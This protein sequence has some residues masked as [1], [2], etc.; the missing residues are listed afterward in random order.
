VIGYYL[1][2]TGRLGYGL[3]LTNRQRIAGFA[4]SLMGTDARNGVLILEL[5]TSF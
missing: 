2:V 1:P 4:D 5:G 3:I